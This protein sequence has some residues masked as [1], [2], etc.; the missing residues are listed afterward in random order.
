MLNYFEIFGFEE[1]FEINKQKLEDKY[2]EL[3]M[4]HHPDKQAGKGE[5]EKILA[6]RKS[7]D[8]NEAYKGLKND[9]KRAEH[10]FGLNGKFVAKERGN[11][12]TP[13][14]E[15]L[16]L[17]LEL[18]EKMLEEGKPAIKEE[19]ETLKTE[20]TK[21][22]NKYYIENKLEAAAQEYFILKFL[23]KI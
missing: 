3:Q 4:Q 11:D 9:V 13:N 8:I 10:L 15:I 21:N 2:L 18:N 14:Q 7:A 19:V 12:F 5:A 22:F 16:M 6:L 20:A 17:Q 1:S 23:S